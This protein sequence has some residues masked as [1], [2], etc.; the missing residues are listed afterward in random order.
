M[1]SWPPRTTPGS[2]PPRVVVTGRHG[3]S[4][5]CGTFEKASVHGYPMLA[6]HQ[7]EVI[8]QWG[9][10][11]AHS[12]FTCP[13]AEAVSS[14]AA[15]RR[16][17]GL[18]MVCSRTADRALASRSCMRFPHG[19]QA[20]LPAARKISARTAPAIR[21]SR[22]QALPR[23][24]PLLAVRVMAAARGSSHAATFGPQ[25]ARAQESSAGLI[26]A[27]DTCKA[28]AD[29]A[30]ARWRRAGRR[31]PSCLARSVA[32]PTS[33]TTTTFLQQSFAVLGA[34]LCARVASA[35]V[36]ARQWSNH[37]LRPS[38]LEGRENFHA[39]GAARVA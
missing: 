28:H 22:P 9:G 14:N 30:A 10:H 24:P 7:D 16:G 33:R 15:S 26:L 20:A 13:G 18:A 2:T 35:I 25:S 8:C 32:A 36:S 5:R 6:R 38:T 39:R 21:T 31:A 17:D 29:L 3:V 34:L 1:S 11:R 19:L 23:L 4:G 12:Y 27:G 37:S